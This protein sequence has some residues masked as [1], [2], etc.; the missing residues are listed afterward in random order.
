MSKIRKQ[1]SS[2]FHSLSLAL[3][4]AYCGNSYNVVL[5]NLVINFYSFFCLNFYNN[6]LHVIFMI[7]QKNVC[8]CGW[9]RE[10]AKTEKRDSLLILSVSHI[11]ERTCVR[12]CVYICDVSCTTSRNQFQQS[13]DAQ[14]ETLTC[15][16]SAHNHFTW[17]MFVF[18]FFPVFFFTSLLKLSSSHRDSRS[19][20]N[21]S[22]CLTR[23]L[24]SEWLRSYIVAPTVYS[25]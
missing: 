14:C 21:H 3:L 10:T 23:A 2:F 18:L 6:V 13:Y 19:K 9:E 1:I 16:H 5:M 4:F 8:V 12:A 20:N 15:L 11:H 25:I 24:E 7:L 22:I 17:W